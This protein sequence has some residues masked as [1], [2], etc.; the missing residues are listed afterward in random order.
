[1]VCDGV[2]PSPDAMFTVYKRELTKPCRISYESIT[3]KAI[4]LVAPGVMKISG[5]SPKERQ[6]LLQGLW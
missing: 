2:V 6:A 4:W 1:M 5:E 3:E